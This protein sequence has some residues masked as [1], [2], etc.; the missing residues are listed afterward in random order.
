M[1]DAKPAGEIQDV[2]T[3]TDFLDYESFAYA[4]TLSTMVRENLLDFEK[5]EEQEGIT[6]DIV[7]QL[8]AKL[9]DSGWAA[10]RLSNANYCGPNRSFPAHDAEHV[11]AS[12][13]LV[14][15]FKGKASTRA[16]IKAGIRR[17]N[18]EMDCNVEIPSY[19]DVMGRIAVGRIPKVV[20]SAKKK[21]S[22]YDGLSGKVVL[23]KTAKHNHTHTSTLDDKGNGTSSSSEKHSHKITAGKVQAAGKDSHVHKL[24]SSK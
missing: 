8:L 2:G 14:N 7:L 24:S 21:K 18:K 16:K 9:L 5:I 17:K 10:T 1:T 15:Y 12:A 6:T 11:K 20:V 23:S 3:N 22:V 19:E 4:H 13:N